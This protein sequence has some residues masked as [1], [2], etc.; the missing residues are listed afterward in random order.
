MRQKF[1]IISLV[2]ETGVE[3]ECYSGLPFEWLWLKFLLVGVLVVIMQLLQ[4]QL[5]RVPSA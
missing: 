2:K 3:G 4:L 1:V 5:A